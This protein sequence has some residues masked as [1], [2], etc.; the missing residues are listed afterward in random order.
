MTASQGPR[1]VLGALFHAGV[2]AREVCTQGW[3]LRCPRGTLR[4]RGQGACRGAE[5]VAHLPGD[6]EMDFCVWWLCRASC[7][8]AHVK[9]SPRCQRFLSTESL[10]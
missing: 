1:A 9:T 3:G 8:T 6:W 7:M 10:L 4:A 5:R 2:P